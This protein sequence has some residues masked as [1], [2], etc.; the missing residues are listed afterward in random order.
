[1][2]QEL[3]QDQ[4]YA[5]FIARAQPWHT[6]HQ[7]VL[8]EM[9]E[10]GFQPVI[11]LGSCNADANRD[12]NPFTFAERVQIIE[13]ACKQLRH[14]DGRS[15]KP[16][17]VPLYDHDR[18]AAEKPYMEDG[19]KR[20]PLNSAWFAEFVDFFDKSGIKPEQFTLFYSAKDQDRK[21]YVFD[22]SYSVDGTEFSFPGVTQKTIFPNEDLSLAFELLGAKRREMPVTEENATDIRLDFINKSDLLVDGTPE[23]IAEILNAE[24]AKNAAFDGQDISREDFLADPLQVLKHERRIRDF[25]LQKQPADPGFHKRVLMIGGAGSLGLPVIENMLA[26]GH[27]LVLNHHTPNAAKFH[28][29]V[30]AIRQHYPERQVTFQESDLRDPRTATPEYWREIYEKYDIDAVFNMAGILSENP[31]IGLTFEAVNYRPIPAMAQAAVDVGID[32]MIYVS[33]ITAG[34]PDAEA[35]ARSETE[36]LTYAG[37]KRKAERALEQF[38][39][40]LNWISVRPITVFNPNTPDWGRPM[41][42]PHLANLAFT[43]MIGS[44]QQKLQPLY[45]GDL[46][47][48]ARLIESPLKGGQVFE[49]VG[50]EQVTQQQALALLHRPTDVFTAISVDY[51]VAEFMAQTYPYGSINPSFINVM[52]QRE[53]APDK[54][55][56]FEDWA[57]AIGEEGHLTSLADIYANPEQDL[58]FEEPPIVEYGGMIA[59]NPEPL[60]RFLARKLG[61]SPLIESF[62]SAFDAFRKDKDSAEARTRVRDTVFDILR[63][64]RDALNDDNDHKPR[65]A[66]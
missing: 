12:K 63:A 17:F 65:P 44:G 18:P 30:E 49:A 40:R 22:P 64:M 38:S 4:Q 19:E 54:M 15:V 26:N 7:N 27:D 24:R 34:N 35:N 14:P 62:R 57:K 28:A 21:N 33:T 39:G 23:I 16:I 61:E 32:R 36:P 41:N 55:I 11:F 2:D 31:E 56:P 8:A 47:K 25:H 51:D 20:V 37:S 60:F 53:T 46:A 6:G 10:Q 43:P 3:S 52:K 29:D 5:G 45:I 42:L 59:R 13:E 58:Q 9:V 66:T 50:P 1:M 48:A